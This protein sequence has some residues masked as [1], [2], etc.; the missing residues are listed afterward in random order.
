MFLSLSGKASHVPDF[1]EFTIL[2]GATLISVFF[3][4]SFWTVYIALEPYVRRRWPQALISWTRV[5]SGKL[6]DPVVGGHILLGSV[7]GVVMAVLVTIGVFGMG[8]TGFRLPSLDLLWGGRRAFAHAAGNVPEAVIRSLFLL[9]ITFFF[10]AFFR[11]EWLAIIGVA[12][13]AFA[14]EVPASPLPPA[15]TSMIVI[16]LAMAMVYLMLRI[17]LLAVVVA[18]HTVIALLSLPITE[19]LSQPGGAGSVLMVLGIAAL[20]TFGFHSTLAGRSVLNLEL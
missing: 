3:A 19:G 2:F 20:A 1:A 4:V 9:F 15:V 6:R 16:P 12:A 8:V 18:I 14:F 7:L 11:L 10:K 17:G 5:L 13:A